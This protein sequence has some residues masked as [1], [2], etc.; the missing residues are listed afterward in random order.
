MKHSYG[1]PFTLRQGSDTMANACR[2]RRV[3]CVLR[4]TVVTGCRACTWRSKASYTGS[5]S[6]AV[7]K[8]STSSVVSARHILQRGAQRLGNQQQCHGL[9]VGLRVDADVAVGV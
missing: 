3:I 6:G 7:L 2:L 8:N 4:T 1:Q 9:A 5:I